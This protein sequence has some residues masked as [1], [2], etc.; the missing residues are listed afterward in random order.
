MVCSPPGAIKLLLTAGAP[1]HEGDDRRRV[2]PLLMALQR[3]LVEE[4]I[5]ADG[6]GPG[7]RKGILHHLVSRRRSSISSGVPVHPDHVPT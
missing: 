7:L 2:A 1:K 6:A 5:L 4:V 3:L